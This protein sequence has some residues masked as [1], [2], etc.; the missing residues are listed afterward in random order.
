MNGDFQHAYFPVFLDLEGR[1][2]VVIGGGAAAEHH[3]VS[4]LRYDADILVISPDVSP[5]I[6]A[7]VAEGIVEH[8]ARDYVRGDL[9]GAFLVICAGEEI[10]TCRAVY[11]EAEGAGCLVSAAHHPELCNCIMPSVVQR[12]LMQ[13]AVST[14]G[15]APEVAMRVRRRLE[16]EFGPEW[17]PYMDVL[18]SVRRIALDRIPDRGRRAEL[19]EA[20]ADSDLL[21]RAAAGQDLSA[22]EIFLEFMFGDAQSGD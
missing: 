4:L 16:S 12:G 11:L 5:A 21:E 18:G 14:A 6:D 22:E 7:L 2:V 13:I 9:A 10:E 15:A 3:V 17:E 19:F 20:I 1:L 8:E